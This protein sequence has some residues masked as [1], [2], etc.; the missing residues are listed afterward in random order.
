LEN[1][2]PN[3]APEN[4]KTTSSMPAMLLNDWNPL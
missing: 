2:L 1:W 3:S 4:A